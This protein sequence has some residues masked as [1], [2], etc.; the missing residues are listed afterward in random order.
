MIYQN[1]LF[2]VYWL[3]IGFNYFLVNYNYVLTP[4][5]IA[6]FHVVPHV[7]NEVSLIKMYPGMRADAVCFTKPD[8]PYILPLPNISHTSWV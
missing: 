3:L 8:K 4:N 6:E 1:T 5:A 2:V 7:T